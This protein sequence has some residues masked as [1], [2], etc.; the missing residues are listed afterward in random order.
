MKKILW[1]LGIMMGCF[2]ALAQQ[3][4][5]T[6]DAC[7]A[8]ATNHYR[9]GDF[10]VALDEFTQ[11]YRAYPEK[12]TLCS[13]IGNCYLRLDQFDS[14]KT[15]F[16]KTLLLLP[17]DIEACSKLGFIAGIEGKT[18]S[19]ILIYQH[20][21]DIEPTYAEAYAGIG[22]MYYWKNKPK[23]AL[24]YYDKAIQLD[25]T[26]SDYLACKKLLKKELAYQVTAT[27][28]YVTEREETYQISAIIQRYGVEKRFCDY[29]SLS[30]NTLWDYSLRNNVLENDVRRWFDNS[31]LKANF[32]FKNQM[33][34][35]FAGASG[36]ENRVTSYGISWHSSFA[37]KKLYIKNYFTAAYDYYYYWNDIGHD[38]YQDMLR[39]SY[40]KLTVSAM[41]RYSVVRNK[42]VWT[43]VGDEITNNPAHRVTADINYSFFENPKL[44]VGLN[45]AY[46]D[47]KYASPLYYSPMNRHVAGLF[48]SNFYRYKKFYTY[49]E[50]SF[51]YDMDKFVQVSTGAE[52]G[53]DFGKISLGLSGNYFYN[54][55]YQNSSLLL[56]V[57][58]SL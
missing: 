53:F 8:Q 30:V 12:A 44:I 52:V 48:V 25:P 22:K 29:F 40:K 51:G 31:W 14:A 47:Y 9:E 34:S 16:S 35:A 45:Y 5:N 4:T 41:Y 27:G 1:L 37:I 13:E 3:D 49:E 42:L 11:L 36:L 28:M 2:A 56:T 57:K 38:Y 39:F 58:M 55:Y 17:N 21:I 54:K 43:D 32:M 15:C 23:S 50:C 18:D 7:F 46:M 20:I 26:N 6:Y 24:R 33:I 19:A 10:R